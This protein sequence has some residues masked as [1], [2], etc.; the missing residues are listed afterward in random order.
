MKYSLKAGY[1]EDPATAWICPPR[2]IKM[3]RKLKVAATTGG[4]D[5]GPR[6]PG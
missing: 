4:N 6:Q 5:L 1:Q 3:A 2:A